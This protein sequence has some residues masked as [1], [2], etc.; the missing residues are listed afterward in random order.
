MAKRILFC[1][2]RAS[3]LKFFH[4][5]YVEFFKKNDFEIHTVSEGVPD[6]DIIDK[7]FNFKFE[8]Q[9][10]VF[11]NIATIFKLAGLIKSQKY[12]VISS[13]AT[14]AGIICRIAL[15]LSRSKE[16]VLIHTSHGYLFKDDGSFKSHIYILFEQFYKKRVKFLFVM[17]KEDFQIAKKYK[18][19]RNIQFI[20]GMG[21]CP[22]KF[23]VV[24]KSELVSYRLKYGIN[25]D[26][27]VFVCVGEFSK[28]KNQQCIINAFS[29]IATKNP[30]AK[31]AFAGNGLLLE[32]YKQL[33]KEL[34]IENQ[35][36]FLGQVRDMNI[37]YRMA[38]VLVSASFSEGLPFNIMEA[39]LCHL[40]VI[41]SDVKG[42]NDLIC[43]QKNGL[44]FN[45]NNDWGLA[46]LMQKIFEDKF[47]YKEL[48]EQS[49]L[50]DKYLLDK[51]KPTLWEAYKKASN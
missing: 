12:N 17:N 42:H 5:P 16:T 31:L 14:L 6:V 7:A 39:M 29:R 33:V 3:H 41:A 30:S 13:Q 18:L 21:V 8:K 28:R 4:L 51:V 47:L 40:P 11:A 32:K 36:V 1:A 46:N 15:F 2:S 49:F 44:L 38:N 26:N 24:K 35:V 50:P 34:N 45:V 43:N 20:N 19:G 37:A 48:K 23:P 22:E 9:K 27:F 10:N 25:S